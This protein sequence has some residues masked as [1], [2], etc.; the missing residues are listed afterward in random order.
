MRRQAHLVIGAIVFLAYTYPLYLLLRFPTNTM[1]I[2][3][4]AVLFGSVMP[5]VLEPARTWTHRGLG[6]SRRALKISA[7]IFGISALLG[8][9]SFFNPELSLS[10][11]VSGFFLGYA[12]HLLADSTTRAGLPR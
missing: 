12:V 3:F 2:G 6:H 9:F 1:L 5:D 10:Y 8:L 4:F 11:V 7:E